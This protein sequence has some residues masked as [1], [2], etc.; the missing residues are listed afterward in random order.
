MNNR[1]INLSNE[2]DQQPVWN[3][4]FNDTF[5]SEN[6]Q[7]Q[8]QTLFI[9]SGTPNHSTQPVSETLRL[10]ALSLNK[11]QTIWQR[12]MQVRG[13]IQFRVKDNIAYLL[14]NR[15][16]STSTSL[17]ALDA[18]TGQELWQYTCTGNPRIAICN[19]IVFLHSTELQAVDGKTGKLLWRYDFRQQGDILGSSLSATQDAIFVNGYSQK[20]PEREFFLRSLHL[21]TGKELWN[22][23]LGAEPW[24][25]FSLYSATLLLSEDTV[26]A[27]KGSNQLQADKVMAFRVQDGTPLWT[28]QSGTYEKPLLVQNNVL[29]VSGLSALNASTGS[30]LWRQS[31]EGLRFFSA[32]PDGGLYGFDSAGLYF[33]ALDSTSGKRLWFSKRGRSQMTGAC[34]AI[35]QTS[36]DM[37]T[38]DHNEIFLLER[39]TGNEQHL[40]SIEGS[41]TAA[42]FLFIAI[43]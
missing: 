30:P 3:T 6:I 16:E 13:E 39:A 21:T 28:S 43:G 15:V 24:W 7:Q 20:T 5:A 32:V 31:I 8:G 14:C 4:I 11:K 23:S 2:K 34:L 40:L 25:T 36:I 22:V 29:L 19:G 41:E 9:G 18:G 10:V 35:D 33:S 26:Y 17:V 27:I 1:I 42:R 12:T 37:I 38:N